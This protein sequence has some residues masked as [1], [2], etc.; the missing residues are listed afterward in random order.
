MG[1]NN[2]KPAYRHIEVN[3]NCR[4]SALI[5]T[6]FCSKWPPAKSKANS[7]KQVE[8][9]VNDRVAGSKGYGDVL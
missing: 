2:F 6:T 5:R 3:K 7:V 8:N 4:P 1:Q 9:V